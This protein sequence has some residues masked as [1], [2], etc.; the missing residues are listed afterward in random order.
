MQSLHK[1]QESKEHP[2]GHHQNGSPRHI[3]T[4][5]GHLV[6]MTGE[7]VGTF[8]FLYFSYAGQVMLT[9]QASETSSLN[10]G[11]S[12][13]TN[14]FTALVYG[15]SLLVSVWAFYRISGGLF[16]PAVTLGM[17]LSGTLPPIRAL[18]LF[19]TQIIAAMCAAGL[20]SCMFSGD[21]TSCNT[22]LAEGTSIAQGVFIEIFMTALLVFVV[23]MLAAEKSKDTF[24]APIGIGLALFV[25]MLGGVYYTGGSLNP[26]RSF[27]P[28]VAGPSFP[29]YHWVYWIGP[30]LGAIIAAGYYRFVKHFNYEEANP[31]QDSAGGGFV[32]PAL[33]RELRSGGSADG[34]V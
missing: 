18:C 30:A 1:L 2:N 3:D 14:V 13:Q 23:L 28:A 21:I 9:T 16:N 34:M 25:A 20:V 6:A 29:G 31:G 26:A 12:A 8:M 10:G 27:G 4:F 17:T 19:P 7:F 24:I 22:T 33:S 32:Q 11:K 5:Q 15:F